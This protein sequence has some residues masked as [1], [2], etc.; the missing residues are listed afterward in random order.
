M[1]TTKAAAMLHTLR[2]RGAREDGVVMVMV[3]IMMV[4]FIGMG[5]LAID[6]GSFY[7]GPAPGSDRRRLG[8]ARRQPGSPDQHLGRLE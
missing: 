1:G 6:L 7:Q 2:R 4:V 8:R 5:A 3:A